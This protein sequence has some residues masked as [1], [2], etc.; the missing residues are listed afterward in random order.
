M[1]HIIYLLM[2]INIFLKTVSFPKTSTKNHVF[3]AKLQLTT[4]YF[5]LLLSIVF[6]F[7]DEELPVYKNN[8][9]ST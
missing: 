8:I 6:D 7:H 2:V 9:P 1:C 3:L 4:V 5:N